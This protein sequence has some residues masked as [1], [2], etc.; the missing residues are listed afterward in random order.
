M[1]TP[2]ASAAAAA[3]TISWR[4]CC[5]C[6]GCHCCCY[7]FA[8]VRRS[9]N[10]RSEGCCHCCCCGAIG[11]C[12][13]RCRGALQYMERSSGCTLLA[14]ARIFRLERGRF[15]YYIIVF[16]HFI[17]IFLIRLKSPSGEQGGE[18][19]GRWANRAAG[20]L[21]GGSQACNRG[22]LYVC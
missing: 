1:V 17:R 12:S 5:H 4:R 9:L 6:F 8:I 7:L 18:R 2:A 16:I 21:V 19:T 22:V 15:I 14:V 3:D 20:E 11:R 10:V 13:D